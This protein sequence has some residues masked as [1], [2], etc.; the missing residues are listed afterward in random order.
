VTTDR[1]SDEAP[2]D[3]PA[4]EER[5]RGAPVLRTGWL[6]AALISGCLTMGYAIYW[7]I[8]AGKY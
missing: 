2:G 6:L 1:S 5:Q 4:A 7:L 8:R 3:E